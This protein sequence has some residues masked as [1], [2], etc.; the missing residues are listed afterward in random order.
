MLVVVA[1][2]LKSEWSYLT[3]S[4]LGMQI[5]NV[6]RTMRGVNTVFQNPM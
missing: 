4:I 3:K 1:F 2:W 6:C 5:G